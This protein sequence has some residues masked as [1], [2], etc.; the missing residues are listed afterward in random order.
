MPVSSVA[1]M[2]SVD[3]GMGGGGIGVGTGTGAGTGAGTDIGIGSMIDG[4]AVNTGAG[5]SVNIVV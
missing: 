2:L 1:K 5:G 4:G 3:G